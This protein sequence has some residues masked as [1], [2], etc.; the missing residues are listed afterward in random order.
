MDTLDL[1]QVLAVVAKHDTQELHVFSQ[2][3]ADSMVGG[4]ADPG[5]GFEHLYI[6]S[7]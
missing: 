3:V 1:L 4:W 5:V 7:G 2:E 6:H